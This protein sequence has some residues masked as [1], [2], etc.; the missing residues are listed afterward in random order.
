MSWLKA[1][2]QNINDIFLTE[3]TSQSPKSWSKGTFPNIH[4]ISVTEETSQSPMSWL[5]RVPKNISDMSVTPEVS[6]SPMS[7]LNEVEKNILRIDLTSE[8]SGASTACPVRLKQPSNAPSIEVHLPV[9]HCSM[10]STLSASH[11]NRNLMRGKPVPV[12]VL[13]LIRT[14][15]MTSGG[16]WPG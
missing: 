5:K 16:K 12:P 8:R 1:D 7:W 11:A 4:D 9:P 14:V 15:K 2:M 6:Q 13:S 10:V 3:E